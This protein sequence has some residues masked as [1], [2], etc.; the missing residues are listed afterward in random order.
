MCGV[1]LW[2]VSPDLFQIE[3]FVYD[4]FR[5]LETSSVNVTVYTDRADR[6]PVFNPTQYT[7]RVR[8]DAV[9]GTF[10]TTVTARD[11]DGV[12]KIVHLL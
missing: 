9:Q 7:A 3:I 11:P 5:Q 8:E 4:T 1:Y 12:R 10:L 2:A 6:P